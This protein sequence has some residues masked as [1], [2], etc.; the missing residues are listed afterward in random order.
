MFD[1]LI[2]IMLII[3]VTFVNSC[4]HIYFISY[5]VI[6]AWKVCL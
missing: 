3:M 4:V 5:D 6:V 1:S 2:L